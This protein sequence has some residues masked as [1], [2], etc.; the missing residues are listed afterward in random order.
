[1]YIGNRSIPEDI[2]LLFRTVRV[3][4]IPDSTEGFVTTTL[5]GLGKTDEQDK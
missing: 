4:F 5:D 2:R 1:M 3:L